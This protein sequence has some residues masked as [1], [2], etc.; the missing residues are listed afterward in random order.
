MWSNLRFV[1]FVIAL[2]LVLPAFFLFGCMLPRQMTEVVVTL[3]DLPKLWA[4]VWGDAGYRI[5]WQAFP[6]VSGV[7]EVGTE[8]ASVVLELPRGRVVPILAWPVWGSGGPAVQPTEGVRPAGGVWSGD[9]PQTKAG[10]D[11]LLASD[12]ALTYADGPT[13]F[14][15]HRAAQLGAEIQSFN[16]HRLAVEISHR[17]PDD[18]W[19]LDTQRVVR[20]LCERSMRVD[21]VR[22]VARSE[23]WLDVPEGTWFS[24]SPNAQ[25]LSG[26]VQEIMVAYGLTPFY[27]GADRRLIIVVDEEE[28]AWCA[29]SPPG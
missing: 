11:R 22:E 9:P 17:L 16:A 1:H 10:E 5:T 21:Y 4:D 24:T 2:L 12:F 3:P 18:P 7:V 29:I 6:S 19:L 25:P 14:V 28:R 20:A 8:A 26:G 15:L 13:A 27:D 23:V